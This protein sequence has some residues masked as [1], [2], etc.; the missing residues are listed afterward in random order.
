[1]ARTEPDDFGDTVDIQEDGILWKINHDILHPMGFALAIN[2]DRTDLVLL[3][4]GIEEW[5]FGPGISEQR[6]A[7]FEAML[8]RRREMAAQTKAAREAAQP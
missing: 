8:T 7:A 3:G 2:E 6:S 1:M 4:D 5:T